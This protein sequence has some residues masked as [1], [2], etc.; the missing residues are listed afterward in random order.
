MAT[1]KS[2]ASQVFKHLARF[3]EM[4]GNQIP[5][6]EAALY[7]A[8]F[9]R[10]SIRL[11]RYEHH[12]S[13]LVKD[14]DACFAAMAGGTEA[15]TML[16]NRIMAINTTL[17]EDNGYQGDQD[18]Y[19]DLQNASLIRVIDRR[20]GIP[21]SLGILYIHIAE[22]L[23]WSIE[24]LSFPGHFLVR[25]S[26]DSE[27]AIVDPFNRG[28]VMHAPD[29]RHLLKAIAGEE[30]ELSHD[31]YQPVTHRD[32]LLRLQ[33]N[34]KL[35][36]IEGED[37]VGAARAIDAMLAIAPSEYRLRLDSGVV[38]ARLERY[39]RAIHDLEIYIK[40]VKDPESKYQ[41]QRLLSTLRENANL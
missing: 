33:N 10:P 32:I 3:G 35:R 26:F 1:D 14:T 4:E 2:T 11:E 13:V 23:G 18:S 39:E 8:A 24:G 30:H 6:A 12:L 17:F 22:S 21:I 19:N 16:A 9:D 7:L 20:R 15:S 37:F 40:A 36:M 38:Q 41:A 5:L 34:I 28:R 27:T 29:L 31:Y 25:M